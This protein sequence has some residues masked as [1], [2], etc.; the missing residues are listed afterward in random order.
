MIS[1]YFLIAW[2]NL[3]NHKGFSAINIGGLAVGM[4]VA[5]L[6][7]L[8][9]HDEL[10][11]DRFH[12]NIDRIAQVMQHQTF[13]GYKGTESSIPIPLGQELQNK[14][15]SDFKYL[16]M[17]TWQSDHIL[18]LGDKHISKSGNFMDVDIARMLTL[19]ML[20]GDYDA[21]KEPNSIMLAKST[22][23]ALFG[24]H[25]PMGKT[26]KIDNKQTV[27]VTGVYEDLPFKTEFFDLKFI[28]PWSLYVA[29][30]DW[31]RRGRDERQ[32]GNNSFQLFAQIADHVDM[33]K[34]SEKI[35]MVK[36]DQVDEEEKKFK[37]EIF[38]HPMKDWH[39]RSNWEAGVKTGGFIQYVW[40]FAAVGLF[41]LLLACINFMNLS[42]ARC[43]KRAKEVGIRKS[44]GSLR[45][46]LIKQFFSE[47]FLIVLFAFVGAL[48]FVLIALPG[49]NSITAKQIS[50]PWN[51]SA[52]WII[53]L[54]FILL[55]GLLAGSYPALYLSSFQPVKV[56]KGT[57]KV[58]RYASIPRKVL[59]V[60]QF[61]VSV[62]MIIGTVLV[63]QQILHTKN[64]PLG[65]DNSGMIMMQ[66]KSPDF[67]GK[68]DLLRTELKGNGAIEE[69][70]E[71]SSP[72]TGIW[73][74]NGGF[75][76]KGKDPNLQAEFATVWV[77]HDFGKSVGW[78]FKEG[79]D[80]SRE[81]TADSSN[82]VIN[83]AAVKFMNIEKPIGTVVRWGDDKG[84]KD[85]T[86][87]G[88]VE[89]MLVESP[90][91][92]VKQTIYLMDYNNVNW[93]NFK[94]NPKVG[95]KESIGKIEAAFKKYI[96]SAPFDYKFVD[97]EFANKFES[98]ERV[99]KLAGIFTG[100]AVF[101]SCLGLFGLASF[102][103]EQRTKEI[104]VRK[105]LGASVTNL[106][107]LLSK[108]FT[109][110]VILS[111][112]ISIPLAYYFLNDWLLNYKYRTP[113]SWWIFAIAGASA[114]GI[115]LITVS[116][117]AIKAALANP[118]KSLRTE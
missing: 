93:M 99:G 58:G 31:V 112:L 110:L 2:R 79:R 26:L 59:V 92:P 81:F 16:I 62:T 9:I 63:Y 118:I 3:K 114:L 106:W 20:K 42:T 107:A 84:G 86:I 98:E 51:Q 116:F 46:Q 71:S 115:A 36:Q 22:A 117:Q 88:V 96:P 61:T 8:W 73:S 49:F 68:F 76:W 40:M 100:L 50:F 103:A 41:V 47:S 33:D 108:D 13:N 28:S 72:L 11:Y 6:I 102:T 83:A 109:G 95:A 43:E 44:L 1:N 4:G 91:E 39:L 18:T 66:M 24:E 97:E 111:C 25:E 45:S 54:G 70:S 90:Y 14:Y 34:L 35:K 104:G 85:F 21:L 30:E 94:L 29:S 69:M 57:F 12:T 5:M 65:Y 80:F 10:T 82:I 38:L 55:T 113:F 60:L 7:G 32:W 17:T 19:K 78:Q 53:S 75:N 101:I 15:G 23:D 89:D 27:T 67:Y 74:N 64:R 56:L 52:F 48:V 105:V 37:A 77:T 87:V